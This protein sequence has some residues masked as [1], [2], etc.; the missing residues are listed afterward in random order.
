MRVLRIDERLI[1]G[2]VIIGWVENG[3]YGNICLLHEDIDSFIIETYTSMLSHVNFHHIDMTNPLWPNME[4]GNWLFVIH[5]I[6]QLRAH[7][8]IL[9]VIQPDLINIGG[10]RHDE[11]FKVIAPYAMFEREEY[12]FLMELCSR[13][14]VY[15]NARELPYSR[16]II[17]HK[18]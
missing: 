16:E 18:P 6:Y 4:S 15:I 2:Q 5:D 13:R 7:E 8:E 1:H 12:N 11:P 3:G 10:I 14:K 17:I 9:D